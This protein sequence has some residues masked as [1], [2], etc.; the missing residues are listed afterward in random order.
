M[1]KIKRY[2]NRKLYDTEAKQYITLDGIADLIRQGKDVTVVDYGSGEDLTALTLTQ[3][4]LEQEKKQSG[5]LPRSILAGLIQTGG[6]R[7]NALQRALTSPLNLLYQ[8]EEEIKLR[9]QLLVKQGELSE[10]EASTLQEK[11]L[12]PSLLLMRQTPISEQ[13]IERIIE[14]RNIPTRDDLRRLLDQVEELSIKL[15]QVSK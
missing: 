7:L 6:D 13:Q 2:P 8:F 11:L 1:T 3:I 12:N 4:I 9:I 10:I 14:E 15:D 5:L